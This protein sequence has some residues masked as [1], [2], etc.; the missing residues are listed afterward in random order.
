MNINTNTKLKDNQGKRM[1]AL[2]VFSAAIGYMKADLLAMCYAKDSSIGQE[3]IRWVLTVPALWNDNAKT[4]MREA[5]NRAGIPNNSLVM[6]L[7]PE[8]ASLYC[9]EWMKRSDATELERGE[10]F[11]VLDAGGGTVDIAVHQ[12]QENGRIKELNKASGGDWGGIKV[13]Q[14]FDKL[15]KDIVGRD[16]LSEIKKQYMSDYM[17]I[18]HSFERAKRRDFSIVGHDK[19]EI[20][21][22]L[23]KSLFAGAI[24]DIVN[25]L[26]I[27]FRQSQVTDLTTMFMVGGYSECYLLQ[28]AI[29]FKFSSLRVLIPPNSVL[30][31]LKGAVLYGHSPRTFQSRISTFTYGIETTEPFR[32]G[33]PVDKKIFINGK[34]H[35]DKIFCIHVKDGEHVNLGKSVSKAYKTIDP[36]QT[37][38]EFIV[39]AS[40]K[41]TPK[42]TDEDGCFQL[43]SL[44]VDVSKMSCNKYGEKQIRLELIYGGTELEAIATDTTTGKTSREHFTL[45]RAGHRC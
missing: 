3:Q 34:S 11:I 10:K 41:R 4:F 40:I 39:Y 29:R 33:Y 19:L 36:D 44:T 22:A 16:L 30:S 20:D 23:F 42:F 18:F 14:E 31:V 26:S 13:D 8:A 25:H 43:G 38:M 1:S 17:D 24:Y 35:C 37:H 5:A 21:L 12:I 28:E 9:I 15:L 32:K 6:A 7:E 45:A 27:L 2:K